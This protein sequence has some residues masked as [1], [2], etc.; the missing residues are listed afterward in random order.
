LIW[1]SVVDDIFKVDL[2]EKFEL[3]VF[4][5]WICLI[6]VGF[7]PGFVSFISNI[8]L[9]GVISSS[10]SFDIPVDETQ[11]LAVVD[12]I[13]VENTEEENEKHSG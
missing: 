5:H 4:T 9:D 6:H 13:D 2:H 3:S 8:K 12:V 10:D 11:G 7:L 1:N